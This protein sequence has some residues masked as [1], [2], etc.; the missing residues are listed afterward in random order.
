MDPQH[1]NSLLAG[2][3]YAAAA[4]ASSAAPAPPAGPAAAAVPAAAPPASASA[5]A[6]AAARSCAADAPRHPCREPQH[7][8][9]RATQKDQDPTPKQPGSL[10]ER[11]VQ[12]LAE[13]DGNQARLARARLRLSDHVAPLHSAAGWWQA[14]HGSAARLSGQGAVLRAPMGKYRKQQ[15]Q[16]SRPLPQWPLAIAQLP[17]RTLHGCCSSARRSLAATPAPTGRH[18]L[19]LTLACQTAACQRCTIVSLPV[20]WRR[21]AAPPPPVPGPSLLGCLPSGPSG[22]ACLSDG[23]H[24]ALLDGRRLLKTELVDACRQAHKHGERKHRTR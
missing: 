7:L 24:R 8:D 9:Q 16:L 17:P 11:G 15:R 2:A 21:S 23:Q 6:A 20:L 12:H 10:S 3:L 4:A 1:I 19:Q 5:A 14:R 18:V 13:R 22:S